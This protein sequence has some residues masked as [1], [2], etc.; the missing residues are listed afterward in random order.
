[1]LAIAYTAASLKDIIEDPLDLGQPYV[2]YLTQVM[3]KKLVNTATAMTIISSVFMGCSSAIAASRVTYAYSRD[4]LFPLSRYWKIID[5]RTKTPINAV[6][7]N[8]VIGQ[9]LLLLVFAGSTA[10]GAAFSVGA[11]AGFISFTMPTVFRITYSRNTFK[12]GPW[13]LGKFSTPVGI[14]SIAFVLVMIPI[15]CFPNVTGSDLTLDEMNWTGVVYFG[16]MLIAFLAYVFDAHKWY[17]GPQCNIDPHD[18]TYHG[19][20]Q[21]SGVYEG[22]Q[23]ELGTSSNGKDEAKEKITE[24]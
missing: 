7:I 22:A 9:L 21:D 17:R 10:I 16:P 12:P 13:N 24:V 20:I 15:L 23:I 14:V 8:F 5:K 4:N 2:T 6:L 1:M 19:G 18:I 11:I 3:S